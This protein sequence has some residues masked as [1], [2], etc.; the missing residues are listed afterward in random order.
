MN[1]GPAECFQDLFC[2]LKGETEKTTGIGL[3]GMT[4]NKHGEISEL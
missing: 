2:Q 4:G 3:T 1:N